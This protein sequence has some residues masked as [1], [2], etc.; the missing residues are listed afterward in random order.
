M[1]IQRIRRQRMSD[2]W[3]V[4]DFCDEAFSSGYQFTGEDIYGPRGG[5]L[6]VCDKCLNKAVKSS[7]GFLR[8]TPLD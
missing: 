3:P 1:N 5:H 2:E 8:E 6:A 4:C 7:I